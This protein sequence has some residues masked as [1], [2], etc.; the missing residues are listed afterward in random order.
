YQERPVTRVRLWGIDCPE[1]ASPDRPAEPW[2]EEAADLVRELVTER[3]A[4][5][6]LE[7][8]QTRDRYGRLLAHIELDDGTNLSEFLLQA[9]WAK[10]DDRWP[11][12]RLGRFAQLERAAR[13]RGAGIWSTTQ[14]RTE[15]AR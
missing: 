13:R 6:L 1:V 2:A 12:S 3:P 8:H 9:G 11:H 4:M 15:T 10:A 5:L 7:P 14:P